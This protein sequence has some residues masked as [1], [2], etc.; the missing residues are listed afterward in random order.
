MPRP[1]TAT[2]PFDQLIERAAELIA[3]RIGAMTSAPKPRRGRPPGSGAASAAGAVKVK[4]GR[5]SSSLKGAKL[6]MT[7]R[8]EGCTNRS[9]G[10][11]W[12]F[13]CEDHRKTM[14]KKALQASRDAWKAA[15][16]A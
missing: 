5:R 3:S 2:H 1:K 6:N 8:V 13:I 16:P 11:R 4:R 10:P 9:G 12:G 14:G 15:H 7:C